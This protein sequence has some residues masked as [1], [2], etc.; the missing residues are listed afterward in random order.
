[1]NRKPHAQ[2]KTMSGTL[3]AILAIAALAATTAG[4]AFIDT[5]AQGPDAGT[6]QAGTQSAPLVIA[7]R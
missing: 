2:F 7:Q 6:A 5:L 1:M 3:R 4:G